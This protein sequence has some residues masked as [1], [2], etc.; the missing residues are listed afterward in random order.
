M[1]DALGATLST[2]C[3]GAVSTAFY[4]LFGMPLKILYLLAG[5]AA[6]YA[7]YSFRHYFWFSEKET[8]YLRGIALANYFYGGLTLSLVVSHFERLTTWG[9]TYFIAE[10]VIIFVLATIEYRRTRLG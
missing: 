5:L 4:P 6:M 9:R 7:L 3:L 2:I 10:L 8:R 1:L